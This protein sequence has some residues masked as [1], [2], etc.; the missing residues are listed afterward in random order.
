MKKIFKLVSILIWSISLIMNPF[1]S[2]V[3]IT[4][5]EDAL[6]HRESIPGITDLAEGSNGIAIADFNQDGWMDILLCNTSRYIQGRKRTDSIRVFLN[7]G[8]LGFK[9]HTFL[10]L[11]TS[12][13]ISENENSPQ[14][15]NLADFNGDGYLD[16]FISRHRGGKNN[17]N[18]KGNSLYL[19]QG[20]FDVFLDVSEKMGIKNINAYN[21]ASSIADI[22][23][24]GW[25][26]IAVGADNI[27]NPDLAGVPESR[28]FLFQ[29]Q[30]ERF[31]DGSYVDIGGTSL[32]EGFGGTFTC[33]YEKD[34]GG[35]PDINLIDLDNDGDFDL[36]QSYH[37]DMLNTEPDNPCASAHFKFGVFVWKNLLKESGSF[38][39]EQISANGLAEWGQVKYDSTTKKVNVLQ[40][41]VRLPYLSFGDI[42]NDSF[43]DV[44]A[45]GPSFLSN[46]IEL[47]KTR[48]KLW[49]NDRFC[50]FHD[51]TKSSGLD[52]LTWTLR[53]WYEFQGW[54]AD[55]P[56]NSANKMIYGADAVFGDYNND[57]F[58]DFV[59]C[60]RSEPMGR[61]LK[62]RNVL[63]LNNGDSSFTPQPESF[64]GIASNSICAEVADFN[65]DGFLDLCFAAD[66]ENTALPGQ[67][68]DRYMDKIYINQSNND[69]DAHHWMKTKLSGFSD[70]ELVG[71]RIEFVNQENLSLICSR[72]VS[73][74]HSYKSSSPLEV[75][76]GMGR[77]KLVTIRVFTPKGEVYTFSNLKTNQYLS[78]DLLHNTAKPVLSILKTASKKPNIV[79]FLT[80]DLDEKLGTMNYTPK[81][82]QYI[83]DQGIVWEDFLITDTLCCPSRSTI[84]RGQFVHNHG[85]L[86]N[87]LPG[88]GFDTFFAR[89]NEDSTFANW[90]QGVGYQ[91]GFFGKYLNG[92]PFKDDLL[93]VPSGWDTW[94]SPSGGNPYSNFNYVMNENGKLITYGSKPSD[95]ITDV[96]RDKSIDFIKKAKEADEPFLVYLSPYVPHSPATPAPRHEDLFP[97]L[98]TPR[99]RS[100]NEAD[101]SDK[102]VFYQDKK[103]LGEK[104]IQEMDKFYRKR[105]QSMQA[106]DE[107]VEQVVKAVEEIGE[108]ENTYFF[109]TSDNGFHMGQHRLPSGKGTAYEE[110][111]NVPMYVRGPG[112]PK[113][114]TI[115]RYMGGNTDLAS[116]FAEIAGAEEP[117]FVDGRSL[118]PILHG[119]KPI[120]RNMFLVEYYPFA[121]GRG[122]KPIELRNVESVLEPLDLDEIYA[123]VDQPSYLAL[124]LPNAKFI[125]H[126]SGEMEYYDLLKDPYEMENAI[127][128]LSQARIDELK[129]MVNA[130]H[131]AQGD[132]LRELEEKESAFKEDFKPIL[133]EL[134]IGKSLASVDGKLQVNRDREITIRNSLSDCY[135]QTVHT[136]VLDERERSFVVQAPLQPHGELPVVFFFHGGGGSG[137]GLASRGFCEMV[138]KENF[139]AVYPSGWKKNWNDGRNASRIASHQEGVDDVKFVRA[140]VDELKK[141]HSIDCARIFAGGVSNG[142]IF[143]HCLAAKAADLFAGIAPVIGGLAEPLANGFKPSHPISLLVIQ[144]D[145]DPLVPIDGG[146]IAGNDRGGR[147]IATEDMLKLYLSRN[148]ITSDPEIEKLPDIDP[149]DGTITEVRHYPR[150]INGVRVEYF[151]VK[152]GGHTMPTL[153]SK[154]QWEGKAGKT[155]RDFDGLTTI[156]EFFRT[157]PSRST[158]TE[159]PTVFEDERMD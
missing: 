102:P 55:Y 139:L 111:I 118:L 11:D 76:A 65:N 135:V 123:E 50:Q 80:D 119:K 41:A 17:V 31:E 99:I 133:I 155:S 57:G 153:R 103:P 96:L 113:G 137:E 138:A 44:L 146:P 70:A 33:D 37:N 23:G 62:P 159:S 69:K 34:K 63:Y 83:K 106:I 42:N 115:S 98:K 87:G 130:L 141:S 13:S 148:G 131:K 78:L 1:H 59:A 143:S 46:Q 116:T 43:Q 24:D 5:I 134:W 129:T 121:R 147:I 136:I 40:D 54:K 157:I 82:D 74:N 48:G 35:G 4:A 8:N 110:D 66:P 88:G 72:V 117:P 144:G 142:G 67:K 145:E 127:K 101:I 22:N 154:E 19:S 151:L 140:I 150:G 7:Q 109:F 2:A 61:N 93:H 91:T 124:R 68:E 108:L 56:K 90:L 122:E 79:L 39:L 95:Y 51:F 104:Q 73:S 26:D 84:A 38:K 49:I 152:G 112:I 16:I 12:K 29:P 97:N 15:P 92:Y 36:V 28:I 3:E 120:W 114:E 9:P 18:A 128:S 156:W 52:S 21:R 100:F 60:D 94:L 30:G 64:S 27:G 86:T 125:L 25:L 14:I 10:F 89:G 126:Q 71:S 105:I 149:D 77:H 6:F 20:R 81:I 107:M 132:E 32:A 85:V 53:E 158:D 75:H 58:L 45:I 47:Q